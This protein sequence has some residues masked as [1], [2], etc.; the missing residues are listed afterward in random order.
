MGITGTK[1]A[2]DAADVVI[3]DDKFSSIVKAILWGRCVYDAIRRFLQ[4]QLTVNVVALVLVFIGAVTGRG[5]P[6]NAVMMLWV[7]LV[8]D[9]LGA[10]ALA[11][12]PPNPAML[13]RR[14]YKREAPLVS[15]P[16]WRNVLAQAAFQLAVCFGLLFGGHKLFNCRE[17]EVCTK[18]KTKTEVTTR[19]DVAT[20][21]I[22]DTGTIT[23]GTFEKLYPEL[24][25]DSFVRAT[26]NPSNPGETFHFDM[27]HEYEHLCFD[28]LAHDYTHG[29]IVFNAFIFC[30]RECPPR[31]AFYIDITLSTSPPDTTCRSLLSSLFCSLFSVFNEYTSRKLFDEWNMFEGVWNNRMFLYVSLISVGLQIFLVQL[32]GEWVKTSPLTLNQWIGTIG[33]GALGLPV[34]VLQ[35]FIPIKED[36]NSFYTH[37]GVGS[38]AAGDKKSRD[39]TKA[40]ELEAV[41]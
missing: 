30:Q 6:L 7:N 26:P 2:Q 20:H 8:M 4:F 39:E 32:G 1:V 21:K 34:G 15:R 27:L 37:T 3:L 36:E 11:T 12:E 28:C 38:K 14:P 35:R 41:V 10:L 22:S 13:E 31:C 40:G 24:D 17:G 9:T 19:W 23:C 5:E 25:Y 29:T 33:I 16:M 18:F